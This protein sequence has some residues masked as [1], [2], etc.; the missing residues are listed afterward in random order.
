MIIRIRGEPATFLTSKEKPWKTLLKEG[1][2]GFFVPPNHGLHVRFTVTSWKRR[3]HAFDLDNLAKPVL[4]LLKDVAPVFVEARVNLG[5]R[6]GVEITTS[7]TPTFS[8]S[9][10]SFWIRKPPVRST[11]SLEVHPDLVGVPK[12][13][14]ERPVRVFLAVHE[15]L[16]VTDFGFT[17]FVKPTLDLLWPIFGGRPGAPRDDRVR[18]LVVTGSDGRASGVTVSVEIIRE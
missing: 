10:S 15:P 14:S 13:P 3:G 4:D 18:F 7:R 16:P 12:I 11:K 17:G 9:G 8:A 2:D 5:D 1:L 6:P